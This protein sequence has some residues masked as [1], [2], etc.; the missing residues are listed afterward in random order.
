QNIKFKFNV[1]HD[2][3]SANCEANGVRLRMQGRVKSDQIEKY[4]IHEPLDRFIIN[5]H[6]FHNA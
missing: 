5:T 4:I 1:Q 2:C 6:A 3:H